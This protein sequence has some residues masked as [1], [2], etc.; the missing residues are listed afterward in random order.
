MPIRFNDWPHHKAGVQFVDSP[1]RR[2]AAKLGHAIAQYNLGVMLSKGQGCEKNP[3]AAHEWYEAAA[4][5]DIPEAQFA[6]AEA[7][8]N[9][10]NVKQDLQLAKAWYQRA[11]KL[12][13]KGSM[14]RLSAEFET[15]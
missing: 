14:A 11:A 6:L 1:R 7:Y 4:E 9:G 13:H 8:Y 12:G 2:E 10:V 15:A 3:A 5:Q